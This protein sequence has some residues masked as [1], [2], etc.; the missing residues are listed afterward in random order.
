MA[1]R[2]DVVTVGTTPVLLT[3]TDQE[4]ADY[5]GGYTLAVKNLTSGT[6]LV[7]DLDVEQA[8]W[9]PVEPGD[10]ESYRL[11]QGEQLYA[12]VASGSLDLNTLLQGV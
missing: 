4:L 12:V 7:G 3:P 5:V 10:R 8:K 6:V 11:D 9:W 1:V 2:P